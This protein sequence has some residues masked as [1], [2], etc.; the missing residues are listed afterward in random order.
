MQ[1]RTRRRSPSHV[2]TMPRP[3]KHGPRSQLSTFVS[4]DVH[5]AA[6]DFSDETGIPIAR[7]VDD[8]LRLYLK[9]K[10]REPGRP[11]RDGTPGGRP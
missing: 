3:R 4:E 11:T 2:V 9:S 6:R 7:I 5:E 1:N 8:A 10:G